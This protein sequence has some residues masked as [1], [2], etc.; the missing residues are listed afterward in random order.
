MNNYYLIKLRERNVFQILTGAFLLTCKIFRMF[1]KKRKIKKLD[2]YNINNLCINNE[3]LLK[4]N[5]DN[6]L[7]CNDRNVM[8]YIT[9]RIQDLKKNS[10]SKNALLQAADDACNGKFYIYTKN[11]ELGRSIDWSTD[12]TGSGVWPRK[13]VRWYR[14]PDN[15]PL[16]G[17]YRHI[18]ELNR[19]HHLILLGLAWKI[20]ENELYAKTILDHITSW[21]DQNPVYYTLNWASSMEVS[22]RLI[23]WIF[24][25]SLIQNSSSAGTKNIIY[26]MKG[27]IQHHKYLEDNLSINI[28]QNSGNIKLRNN[29]TIIEICGLLI[30]SSFVKHVSDV[31][32]ER[33]LD[34]LKS[35]LLEEI[36]FQTYNDGMNVEQSTNYQR[37]TLEGLLITALTSRDHDF[38]SS[39]IKIADKHLS[40]LDALKINDNTFLLVGDEDNGHCFT[41]K[42]F[43]RPDDMTEALDMYKT[44]NSSFSPIKLFEP[45]V[46]PDSGHWCWHGFFGAMPVIVYFRAGKMDFPHLPGYAP[47]VHCDLLSFSIFINESPVFV[48]SGSYSYHYIHERNILRDDRSHNTFKLND[49]VQMQIVGMFNTKNHAE[50]KLID[51]NNVSV[52]GT[53]KLIDNNKIVNVQRTMSID[54]TTK[55]IN[56]IDSIHNNNSYRIKWFL[57]IHPD[58]NVNNS[59]VLN[60]DI[61]FSI[62]G[63]PE[64]KIEKSLYSPEYGKLEDS[65]RL[66]AVDYSTSKSQYTRHWQISLLD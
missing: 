4:N 23:N 11:Y 63:L 26:V 29:H 54:I 55:T 5:I 1:R 39:L 6:W 41:T 17:D 7:L 14:F 60:G 43:A 27:I 44:L 37:F 57:N 12:L 59:C 32:T 49:I 2:Y 28:P 56:I 53:M 52:T 51:Y 19:H 50:A 24:A 65:C 10:S 22:I 3:N 20:T 48:D 47:H 9:S 8:R 33:S 34:S 18:W 25:V 31:D 15:S 30:S 21:I 35:L 45:R 46:L 13:F 36:L 42:P 66:V 40:A 64:F 61:A 58:F 38:R 62:N 16:R